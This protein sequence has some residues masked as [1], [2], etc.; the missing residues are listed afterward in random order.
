MQ[1][2][3]KI[4]VVLYTRGTSSTLSPATGYPYLQAF[5]IEDVGNKGLRPAVANSPTVGWA[6]VAAKT[7]PVPPCS[8]DIL[9]RLKAKDSFSGCRTIPT[10]CSR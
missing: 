3:E 10:S 2:S 9:P 7:D 4:A 1:V 5:K 8:V 6:W